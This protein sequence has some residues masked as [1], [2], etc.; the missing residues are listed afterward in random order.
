MR[1]STIIG[2]VTGLVAAVSCGNMQSSSDQTEAVAVSATRPFR[3]VEVPGIYGGQDGL[4]YFAG[5]YWDHFFQGADAWSSDSL[6]VAGIEQGEFEQAFSNYIYTL[7]HLSLDEA[8]AEIR[9]LYPKLETL[10]ADAGSEAFDGFIA[11]AER[12]LYDP[13]SPLRNEDLWN[14]LVD[15]LSKDTAVSQDKRP[16]YE[17]QS[18][19]SALNRVGSKAAD[20]RFCD[21]KGKSRKLYSIE[22]ENVLLFFSNPGCNACKE[23]IENLRKSLKVGYLM[24][25]GKLAVVNVYIDEDIQAWR[26]Y[27]PYYPEEWYNG[28]DP[29]FVIRTDLLYNVR[30]IPSL[31]LLDRDKKVIMKDATEEKVFNYIDNL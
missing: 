7:E 31:Y 6:M 20:F 25:A 23:I 15:A 12:Y 26:E 4:K 2:I 10:R 21:K 5:H 16:Q 3:Q 14:P 18:R 22:A 30:A 28:Y 9:K 24:D 8:C 19:T 17:F 29:D 1:L 11:V 27:M 13:N